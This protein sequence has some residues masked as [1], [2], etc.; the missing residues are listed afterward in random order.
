MPPQLYRLPGR[1][2][3][4]QAAAASSPMGLISHAPT[5][6]NAGCA[7][8]SDYSDFAGK[9]KEPRSPSDSPKAFGPVC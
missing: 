7:E 3:I 1:C 5:A 6:G 2:A 4:I 9:L 8:P